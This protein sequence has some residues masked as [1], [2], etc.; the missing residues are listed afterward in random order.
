M[1]RG[2]RGSDLPRQHNPRVLVVEDEELIRM[3]LETAL[4]GEGYTVRGE[5][6]GREAE[7]SLEQ[8]GPDLAIL[9]VNLPGG[10]NGYAIAR[11]LRRASKLPILFLTGADE[12]ADRLAGFEAGADD[13]M[14]KPFAMPEVLA[15][16]RALLRRSGR[17]T[18]GV[19]QV[20]DLVVDHDRR[21]VKRGD[22]PIE[23]T[24]T[25]YQLLSVLGEHLGQ[26]L[27][28]EQLLT[29]VWSFESVESNVVD[30]H[31]SSLRRKL[32]AHGPRLVHTV[33]GMGYILYP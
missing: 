27:S 2:E 18:A 1:G 25:E 5:A 21:T 29:R 32:E 33:R 14:A 11:R 17:L 9:D 13:Y 30:V 4:K 22:L 19:W 10:P 12:V 3:A 15:R 6:H 16:V 20:S 8:F 7:R 23:L 31:I 28:R 26:V 24:R